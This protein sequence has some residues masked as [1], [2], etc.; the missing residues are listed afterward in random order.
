MCVRVFVRLMSVF[1]QDSGDCMRPVDPAS[2]SSTGGGLWPVSTEARRRRLP[3]GRNAEEMKT[4]MKK[5]GLE[6]EAG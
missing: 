6:N 1:F 2:S 3:T 4:T 5:I